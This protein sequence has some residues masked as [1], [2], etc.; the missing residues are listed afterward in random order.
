[1][2]KHL[3]LILAAALCAGCATGR[4]GEKGSGFLQS[5]SEGRRLASA[6][7]SLEKGD[8]AGASKIL[9]SIVSGPAIPGVTDE[10]LFRL[11]LLSLKPSVERP[12]SPQGHQ[13]LRRLKK[14]F[15]ASPWSVQAT[16][17]V[18]LITTADELKRQNRAYRITN[19]TLSHEVGDLNRTIN[20]LNKN[21]EQLKHLDL[22]LEKKR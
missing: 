4:S 12:A 16:P 18:E 17:L 11:A 3:T 13:L 19:Q 6:R 1:M 21:I 8:S 7:T 22:E 5:F 10:A 9:E 14:E 15:P 20:D 2:K